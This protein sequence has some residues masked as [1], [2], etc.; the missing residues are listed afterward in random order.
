V[1][2]AEVVDVDAV[3]VIATKGIDVP[4]DIA[5]FTA[6]Q[7][8]FTQFKTVFLPVIE[9]AYKDLKLDVQPAA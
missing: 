8:F 1:K 6:V 9:A 7:A 4:E 3:Q 2:S 5:T